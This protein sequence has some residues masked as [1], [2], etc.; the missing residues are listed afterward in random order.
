M[1]INV[2]PTSNN[3]RFI[4]RPEQRKVICIISDTRWLLSNFVDLWRKRWDVPREIDE[5]LEMPN[6]FVGVATCD[7]NDTWDEE[8]GRMIAF[9][10]A[11]YKLHTSFFKRANTFVN[12]C[13]S[14]LNRLITNLNDYG[15]R[16]GL[17]ADKREAWITKKVGSKVFLGDEIAD[18]EEE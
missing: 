16:I 9:S 12:E 10:R 1:K 15:E 14:A 17:N 3:V 13:D 5:I 2:K 8:V 6:R 18:S 4:V 7:E 11:K